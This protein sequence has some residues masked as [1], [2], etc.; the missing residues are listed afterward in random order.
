MAFS[1]SGFWVFGFIVLAS[2]CQ[3]E[4]PP[5]EDVPRPVR[6]MLVGDAGA[7]EGRSFPGR[8]SA[9]QVVNLSFRVSGP[10]ITLPVN[11]GDVVATGDLLARMDPR[12][13]ET[14]VRNAEGQ[15]QRAQANAERAKADLNRAL[16]IQKSDPGAISQAVIDRAREAQAIA[17][18]DIT[19][20]QATLSGA[21]D[22]LADTYLTAPF[23][24]VIV[25]THVENHEYVQ[26]QQPIARLL[27]QSRVEFVVN[28]PETLISL[29]GQVQNIQVEF[30]ALPGV[31]IPAQIK[32]I[33]TEASASTRTFPVTL[34][35]DQPEGATVLPGMAGSASGYMADD[36]IDREVPIV[37]PAHALFSPVEGQADYVWVVTP[38]DNTVEQRQ[39]ELGLL[40]SLGVTV[41]SGLQPGERIATAGVHFLREDQTVRPVID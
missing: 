38:S 31:E 25:A 16:G 13:Y 5:V 29:V 9:A 12:D 10:L 15:L 37:V 17:R 41:T 40:T 2:G 34:I 30:D 35:M 1:N 19:A 8:A 4:P 33:G 36:S 23:D 14:R 32:E 20:L 28:V 11:V 26:A 22:E 24:G 3:G 18:A 7:I 6:T 27:D 21:T 39:V